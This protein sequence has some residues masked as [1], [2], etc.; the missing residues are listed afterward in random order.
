MIQFDEYYLDG[1]VQPPTRIVIL[2]FN[3]RGYPQGVQG[4]PLIYEASQIHCEPVLFRQDPIYQ[5]ISHWN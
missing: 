2:V 3:L 5:S 4:M 1:L